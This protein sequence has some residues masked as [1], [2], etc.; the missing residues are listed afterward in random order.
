MEIRWW[1]ERREFVNGE[2]GDWKKMTIRV[3]PLE[4]NVDNVEKKLEIFTG[5][6]STSILLLSVL[7]IV[8]FSHFASFRFS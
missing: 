3:K 8:D 7:V 6:V 5:W 1:K 4:D 2:H